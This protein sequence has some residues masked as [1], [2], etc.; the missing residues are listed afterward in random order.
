MAKHY[1]IVI[2]FN[3]SNKKDQ[4]ECIKRFNKDGSNVLYSGVHD[5]I[6]YQKVITQK[7]IG[8]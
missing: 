6:V 7:L 2:S 5:I 4:E 8:E 1:N 3:F